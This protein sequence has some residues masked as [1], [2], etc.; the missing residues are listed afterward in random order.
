MNVL[1]KKNSLEKLNYKNIRLER[2]ILK[3]NNLSED[4]KWFKGSR[5]RGIH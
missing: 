5:S 1:L 4:M 2:N 3:D